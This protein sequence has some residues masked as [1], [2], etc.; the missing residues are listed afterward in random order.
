MFKRIFIILGLM[1]VA[2]TSYAQQGITKSVSRDGT[3]MPKKARRTIFTVPADEG[4]RATILEEGFEGTWLP[5]GWTVIQTCTDTSFDFPSFW[6]KVF[7][8]CHTGNY[9]AGLYWSFS[10]Q[11]E[12]L[13]TPD[14]EL[15]GSASGVYY[16]SFWTRG[17]EGSTHDDHYYV[18]VSTDYRGTWTVL[19][20][21]SDLTGNDWN[22]WEYPYVLDLSS[23]AGQTIKLA[24][25]AEDPPSNDGL[26]YSWLIDDVEVGYPLD[27]DV[28]VTAIYS[29]TGRYEPDVSIAPSIEVENFGANNETFDVTFKIF[30]GAKDEVYS[31]T[32]NVTVDRDTSQTVDFPSFTPAVGW[33]TTLAYTQLGTD[34]E[35]AND[36]LTGLFSVYESG[37]AFWTS[38]GPYGMYINDLAIDPTSSCTVFATIKGNYYPVKTTNGGASWDSLIGGWNRGAVAIDPQNPSTIYTGAGWKRRTNPLCYLLKS[39]DGG[40]TWRYTPGYLFMG[41]G[42]FEYGVSDIWV[43]PSDSSI[44]LVAIAGFGGI[45]DPGGVYKTTNGGETWQRTRDFWANTLAADPTNL[46]VLYFGTARN[47]YVFKSTNGGSYWTNISPGGEW[48]WEVRDIEVDLN[49]HVYAATDSGLMKLVGFVW[50]KLAGLPTDDITALAIDRSTTPGVVYAGTDGNGVYVSQDGGSSWLPFNDGLGDLSITVLAISDSEPKILYAG[51]ANHGVWDR[52]LTTTGVSEPV[53][54]AIPI[55]YS[56][57]QN[58]PNPFNPQTTIKYTLTK[59]SKVML[60][61]YNLL[62]QE[63]R[64]LVDRSQLSGTHTITWD[65]GGKSGQHLASGIYFYK[66]TVERNDIRVS[67]TKKM[68]LLK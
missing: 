10:H 43:N 49:S 13:I 66:L 45:D 14:I 23:Y 39:T 11:D 48:V 52:T 62:G 55:A 38:G 65:G 60:K 53:D 54:Q 15:T 26:W 7:Y 63:I 20:D 37:T 42:I 25:H 64:T 32:Q 1:L 61:I 8:L 31:Q 19:L 16:L 68:L 29:P 9:S 2:A 21:L 59:R 35:P 50:T 27:H 3:G 24:W 12:W 33:Y 41:E 47:G 51:T 40:Q 17:F 44:L 67:E 22:K 18:K 36:T 28:S 6:S 58:Y 30:N 5:A 34:E 56:L 46:Q 4:L 57:S